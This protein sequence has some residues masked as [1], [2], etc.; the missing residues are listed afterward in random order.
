LESLITTTI[1]TPVLVDTALGP[2]FPESVYREVLKVQMCVQE[3]DFESQKEI[4]VKYL[5][6]GVGRH[7]LD[8]LSLSRMVEA[9]RLEM[10]QV[11]SCRFATSCFGEHS[12]SQCVIPAKLRRVQREPGSSL[13]SHFRARPEGLDAPGSK[14]TAGPGQVRGTGSSTPQCAS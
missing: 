3:I 12:V 13:P 10:K 4:V 9:S 14:S 11:F 7:R 8:L 2:G 5:G 6:V 1:S